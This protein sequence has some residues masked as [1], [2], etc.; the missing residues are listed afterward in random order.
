MVQSLQELL[1]ES[2]KKELLDNADLRSRLFTIYG[3]ETFNIDCANDPS[4]AFITILESLH[5]LCQSEY[6]EQCKC[7]SHRTFFQNKMF[8]KKCSN[9][10]CEI[11]KSILSKAVNQECFK[12]ELNIRTFQK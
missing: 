4:L 1:N 3:K 7:P 12:Q 6:K 5:K 2:D 8:T 11:N 10:G 9:K